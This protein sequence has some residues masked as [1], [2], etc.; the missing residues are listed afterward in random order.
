MGSLAQLTC[1]FLL[2][3]PPLQSL[4]NDRSQVLSL[5]AQEAQAA[6]DKHGTPRRSVL[7]VSMDGEGV[8]VRVCVGG[9]EAEH[10]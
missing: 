7:K 4:L 9:G 6:A 2:L 1:C 5:V 3:V 8:P 10:E